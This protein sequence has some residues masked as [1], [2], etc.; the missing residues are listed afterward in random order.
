MRIRIKN[1]P[2]LLVCLLIFLAFLIP[3]NIS[4]FKLCIIVSAMLLYFGKNAIK[5][6]PYLTSTKFLALYLTYSLWSTL[7]GFWNHNPATYQ[8][9]RLN[10]IYFIMLYVF[11]MIVNTKDEFKAIL[12][13]CCWAAIVISIYTIL[14]FAQSVNIINLSHFIYLDNI[15]GA[16]IHSGYV[17]ITNMN[18]SMML[19][20]FPVILFINGIEDLKGDAAFNRLNKTSI[21]LSVIAMMMTGRRIIWMVLFGSLL[22]YALFRVEKSTA[23]RIGRVAIIIIGVI[24][25]FCV[26]S[27]MFG[28]SIAGFLDRFEEAFRDY[29]NYGRQNVRW[30]QLVALWKG[31]LENPIFGA[32]AGVGVDE[33]VRST[34]NSAS[35][36]LSYI[37]ILYNA[38]IVGF[39][40]Y[41][42]SLLFVLKKLFIYGKNDGIA[43]AMFYGLAFGLIANATN[44]YF[45]SSFDFLL[46][47]FIP[48]MYLNVIE[49]FNLKSS[50]SSEV[51][52]YAGSVNFRAIL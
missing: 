34:V 29:D 4:I 48:L 6:C 45:S 44:P 47:M 7:H 41:V 8:L 5:I 15:S 12:R 33:V 21:A 22:C 30:L 14:F 50:L 39:I 19:F 20:L 27:R 51:K 46:W 52:K 38:G 2:L 16:M 18:M 31:F 26:L 37:L 13:T 36:E 10:V 9:F 1:V 32:G 11:I 49:L 40:P 3:R 23:K 43:K 28:I 25:V 17:H 24:F 42:A 35:Y